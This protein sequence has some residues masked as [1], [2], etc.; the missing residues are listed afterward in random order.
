MLPLWVTGDSPCL[1]GSRISELVEQQNTLEDKMREDRDAL[2]DKLHK[3]VTESTAVKL[4][5]ERLKV[6]REEFNAR[7]ELDVDCLIAGHHKGIGSY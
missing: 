2:V 7:A 3:Q 1:Y 6:S 4:E 5:N